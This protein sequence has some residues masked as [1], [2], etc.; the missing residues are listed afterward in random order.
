M[1]LTRKQR[2][3]LDFLTS[4]IER[5]GFAPSF[6][7]IAEQFG[8][9]SLATVHEH[10]TNLERKGYI[11]RSFNESRSIEVLPP[12][13]TTG[14]TEIPLLGMVAAG[15]PIESV[16]A[17]E[18]I[19]VP[20]SM[21]PRRGPNY[22]LKV[23]GESM[24]DEQILDGDLVVVNGRDSADNGEMVIALVNGAEATVKRFYREPGGWI[25]LQPANAQMRPL[26]FQES[27]V[28]I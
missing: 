11:R 3:I 28:L 7:E 1:P 27:D 9:Q 8:Y 10:L 18:V 4:T 26:R 23:R 20:D 16:M 22:A 17:G 21:L 2:E 24:I 12:R 19:P 13:G 14:A 5:Q 25:R 15:M 6:E